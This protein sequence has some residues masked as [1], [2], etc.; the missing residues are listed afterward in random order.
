MKNKEKSGCI[1]FKAI[2]LIANIGL[3]SIMGSGKNV[4]TAYDFVHLHAA[5]VKI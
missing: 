2:V 5:E 1:N 3:E 4:I